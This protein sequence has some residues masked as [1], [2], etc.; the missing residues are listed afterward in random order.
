MPVAL[1]R[2]IEL[3][4]EQVRIWPTAS[5]R[6]VEE[7]LGVYPGLRSQPE[8]VA[9]L[10][11]VEFH[12][13]QLDG[14]SPT[15]D[16]YRKQWPDYADAI[17]RALSPLI[18][19]SV[20]YPSLGSS[21]ELEYRAS[22]SVSIP[23]AKR[24]ST[25]TG[26]EN[27]QGRWPEVP[28]YE[29]LDELGEG[30]MAVVYLA[31]HL[32]LNRLVAL[33][34]ILP[35][36]GRST[37]TARFEIEAETVARLQHP[38]IVQIFDV[39]QAGTRD[40]LALEYI[41]GGS[42]D[43]K[44]SS[45]PQPPREVAQLVATI[46]RAV[47]HAH[48]NG[49]LHRDL[50][51]A[52]VLMTRDGVPKITDFGLAKQTDATTRLT[53]TGLVVGTPCYM[54]PEQ[55][56]PKPE[57]VGP[58]TDVYAIGCIL[59]EGLTGRPPLVG[60]TGLDTL[61]Q[62]AERDAVAVRR[63]NGSV[64][65]ALETICMKCLE[66]D[67]RKRYAT[68]AELADDLQRYL[69]GE[70]V[71]AKPLGPLVRGLRWANR[72]RMLVALTGALA[73]AVVAVAIAMAWSTYHAYRVATALRDREFRLHGLGAKLRQHS[74]DAGKAVSIA[75]AAN[76]PDRLAMYYELEALHD[77]LLQEAVQMAPGPAERAGLAAVTG[78]LR[79]IRHRTAERVAAGQAQ[80]G[81]I[82]IDGPDYA[83]L[84]TDYAAAVES[85]A[86]EVDAA[87]DAELRAVR[88]ET[89]WS[90]RAATTLAALL[91]GTGVWLLVRGM[92]RRE[93]RA[94]QSMS[95]QEPGL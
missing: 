71:R 87:A 28:G 56:W 7:A 26:P 59:Y 18:G 9:G 47:Q 65:V 22:D 66:K 17:T 24:L 39:G 12:L 40:Y 67:Q 32:R 83:Q 69:D 5:R 60:K 37:D 4:V 58:T 75:A 94:S 23:G 74:A 44:W 68:A 81:W 55:V 11:A 43:E 10:V 85:F 73:F 31:K 50:K 8:V 6:S 13:R 72:H 14:D 84:R 79:T 33:K 92:N 78:R 41:A 90:L 46:A 27:P 52:N 51:P 70:Q 77:A 19:D 36:I 25:R 1:S 61:R 76:E 64:P 38:N 62:V 82:L 86:N 30:G 95:V 42:V 15:L 57:D 48:D 80:D 3:L 54:A 93:G 2:Y 45:R 35:S 88:A 89:Y 91:G 34:M 21:Q 63:V 49:V 16:E 53:D 20:A 29:I